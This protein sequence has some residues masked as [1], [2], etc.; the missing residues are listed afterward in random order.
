MLRSSTVGVYHF[1]PAESLAWAA[2]TGEWSC[3]GQTPPNPVTNL[4]K[5]EA[6]CSGLAGGQILYLES[7]MARGKGKEMTAQDRPAQEPRPFKTAA[8]VQQPPRSE[9]TETEIEAWVMEELRAD[10]PTLDLLATL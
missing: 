10:K 3:P 6:G 8:E 5:G 7:G 2:C 9:E 1:C 4:L